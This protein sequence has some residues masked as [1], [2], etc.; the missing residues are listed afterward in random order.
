VREPQ[1]G[2]FPNAARFCAAQRSFLG[3]QAFGD[4]YGTNRNQAN[5][6]GKCVSRN[7]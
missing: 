2:D 4:R 5:A 3:D 1:R 6:L 7:N